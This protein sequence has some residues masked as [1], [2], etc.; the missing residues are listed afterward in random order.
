MNS[1]KEDAFDLSSLLLSS[2][3]SR[4]CLCSVV[5]TFFENAL[6]YICSF[7]TSLAPSGKST[8]ENYCLCK[9]TLPFN[10]FMESADPFQQIPFLLEKLPEIT[11]FVVSHLQLPWTLVPPSSFHPF[12]K[13][14]PKAYTSLPPRQL[15]LQ[16]F[17]E[18][19]AFF[20]HL[21][22]FLKNIIE[23]IAFA[24]SQPHDLMILSKINGGSPHN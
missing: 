10:K 2:T 6:T 3:F 5:A 14:L 9:W 1:F 20:P 15:L 16:N 11:I 13:N 12:Y 17:L 22:L 7:F 4:A 23:I 18:T 24:P 8:K 19:N 21:W